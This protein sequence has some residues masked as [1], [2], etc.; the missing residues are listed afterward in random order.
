MS[1]DA[2]VNELL[3]AVRKRNKLSAFRIAMRSFFEPRRD[4]SE[5]TAA[6]T[7]LQLAVCSKD[8]TLSGVREELHEY[9][10]DLGVEES[11]PDGKTVSQA[12]RSF[13]RKKQAEDI[14]IPE[15]PTT[16]EED[17]TDDDPLNLEN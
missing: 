6:M 16:Q 2:F 5:P 15:D 4:D 9:L 11:P 12:I 17:E 8:G 7:L 14:D 10:D 1:D 3:A 13:G